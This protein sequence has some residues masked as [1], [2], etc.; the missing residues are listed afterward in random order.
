M[1]TK[2]VSISSGDIVSLSSVALG[3]D[4]LDLGRERGREGGGGGAH[5]QMAKQLKACHTLAY[6]DM[7]RNQTG[8]CC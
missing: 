5:E 4:Q 2:D 8:P 6:R 3:C 1:Q 7:I